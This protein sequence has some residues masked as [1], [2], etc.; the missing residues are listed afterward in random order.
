MKKMGFRIRKKKSMYV[1]GKENVN[2]VHD[3]LKYSF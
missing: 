3:I 1:F 2:E